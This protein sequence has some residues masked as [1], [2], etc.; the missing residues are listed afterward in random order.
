LA[1]MDVIPIFLALVVF[2]L[3]YGTVSGLDRV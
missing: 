2:V 3:I 1:G